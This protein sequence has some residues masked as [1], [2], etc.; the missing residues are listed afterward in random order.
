MTDRIPLLFLPGLLCDAA[1]FVHQTQH[2]ADISQPRVMDLSR[3]DNIPALAKRVLEEAPP[4][5]AL[6]GLS[7]GGYVALEIMR[8][9]PARVVKLA[10]MDTSARADSPEQVEKRKALIALAE[11]GKFKGVTPRLLP[12]LVHKD[13]I[14]DHAVSEP[15]FKMAERLGKEAF[16][17]Q[18]KAIIGRPDSRPDLPKIKAPTLV[19]VGR[20]DQL[21]PPE[22]ATELSHG[23]AG[24]KLVVIEE[25]GHLAP[26]ERP[27]A[28][29][30]LLR[31][32]LLY[33]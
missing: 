3:D 13:R 6:A 32:W 33:A 17:R 27:H 16:I 19:M 31:Q 10:L 22:L 2:L 5:F 21:T 26:L 30:A 7:M 23:I 4:R 28:V 1:L 20:E 24:S 15:V 18:Q 14:S 12:L 8:Q 25:C 11:T 29:T 9:E